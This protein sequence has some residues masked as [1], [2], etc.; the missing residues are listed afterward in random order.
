MKR[1]SNFYTPFPIELIKSLEIMASP[2]RKN[3][4]TI[5]FS[6][7]FFVYNRERNRKQDGKSIKSITC[8]R[9]LSVSYRRM[10]NSAS[11]KNLQISSEILSEQAFLKFSWKRSK[12]FAYSSLAICK[13]DGIAACYFHRTSFLKTFGEWLINCGETLDT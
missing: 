13:T 11:T 5:F 8:E 7:I 6:A 1:P 3:C 12:N 2:P 10:L 9:N 4:T